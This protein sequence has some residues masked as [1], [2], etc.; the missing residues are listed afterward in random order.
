MGGR[1]QR[2]CARRRLR[3]DAVLP[4][5]RRR[6]QPEDAARSARDQ[7]RPVPRRRRHP[8]RAAHRAAAGRDA[9]VAQGRRDQ[10]RPG[11]GAQPHSRHRSRRRDDQGRERLDQGRR[12][13]RGALGR[14]GLQAAGRSGVFQGRHD[15]VPGRQRHLPP[16]DLR[17][18]SGRAR[19]HEL[20][21]RGP[22][23]AYRRRAACGVALLHAGAAVEGSRRDDPLAVPVDA[24]TEQGRAAPRGRAADQGEEAR[25]DRR[26]L[27]GRERR[28]CLGAR[29]HRRRAGRSRPGLRRQGQGACRRA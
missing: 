12:Q 24:G 19:H 11:E 15:D 27:H 8:A 3:A 14:E 29:R 20:R 22:A 2:A 17:Q 6:R 21:L 7:G 23:V 13:G 1:D 28:L 9:V 4:L 16:R 10:A 25:R 26:R 5:S 18:L